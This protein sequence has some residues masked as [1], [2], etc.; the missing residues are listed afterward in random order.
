[1]NSKSLIVLNRKLAFIYNHPELWEK[2]EKFCIKLKDEWWKEVCKDCQILEERKKKRTEENRKRH[3]LIW[4]Q[5]KEAKEKVQM[6]KA[7]IERQNIDKYRKMQFSD[8]L[9]NYLSLYFVV[10]ICCKGN[11]DDYRLLKIMKREVSEF[12]SQSE[13][14]ELNNKVQKL[15]KL[16]EPLFQENWVF[17]KFNRI[18]SWTLGRYQ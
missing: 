4:A 1:M 13:Q 12:R 9:K 14:E 11:T 17:N 2:L 10:W 18:I 8:L 6:K 15:K 5:Q 3:E 7:E 16:T